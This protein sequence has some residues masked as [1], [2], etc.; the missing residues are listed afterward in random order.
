[1]LL[2]HGKIIIASEREWGLYGVLGGKMYF[3][4]LYFDEKTNEQIQRYIDKIAEMSGNVFMTEN[5]VPPHITVSS[6]EMGDN[7]RIIEKLRKKAEILSSGEVIWCSVGMFFPSVIYITPVLNNYL[8]NLSKNFYNIFLQEE[9]IS[10][11]PYYRPMQWLPHA[12]VGKK[13]TGGEMLQAVQVLQGEFGMFRGKVTHIGL[14][15]TNPYKELWRV[16]LKM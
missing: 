10:V 1:M 8:Q 15:K 12:T 11:S 3:I 4:S 16:E 9:N 5:H 13:L 2:Y 6:F 7:V 14:A